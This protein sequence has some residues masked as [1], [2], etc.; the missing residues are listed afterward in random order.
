MTRATDQGSAVVE[1]VALSALLVVPVVY[2]I[3]TVFTLQGAALAA[4]GAA[5]DAGRL[6]ATHSDL[7]GALAAARSNTQLAFADFGLDVD[8]QV[9]ISCAGG[10]TAP[11]E[12]V[13]VT[14]HTSV[15]LPLL[16]DFAVAGL[17]AHVPIS[18]SAVAVLDRYVER[19]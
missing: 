19:G 4:A 15:P 16:P 7:P 3:L 12:A 1:F 11:G 13:T 10:C 2:L 14:V 17:G 9:E 18:A 5:R 6:I 8:P